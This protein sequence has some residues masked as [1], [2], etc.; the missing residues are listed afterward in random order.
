MSCI[1]KLRACRSDCEKAVVFC[2]REGE[3]LLENI[4]ERIDFADV[5]NV[6]RA[7]ALR[8]VWQYPPLS[9]FSKDKLN[10]DGTLK[11]GVSPIVA[12]FGFDEISSEIFKALLSAFAPVYN[13][14]GEIEGGQTTFLFFVNEEEKKKVYKEPYFDAVR[15]VKEMSDKSGYY[16]APLIPAETVFFG[17]ENEKTL[18]EILPEGAFVW[19]VV[20][21]KDGSR[22]EEVAKM[23]D[24]SGREAAVFYASD[25]DGGD[26]GV[27]S[28]DATEKAA[29]FYAFAERAAYLRSR[30]YDLLTAKNKEE[31]DNA[32]ALAE[33]E[34][35]YAESKVKRDS[36][37]Y[38]AL[39]LRQI[40]LSVG[41][42]CSNSGEDA[43]GDF[44][45]VYDSANPRVR[46][47]NGH[48]RYDNAMCA[49]KSV[50]LTLAKREHLRWNGYMLA[51]GISPASKAEHKNTDKNLLLKEGR[52]INLTTW[53]GLEEYRKDE[54][55][56]KGCS[57][58]ETDVQRYDF[59]LA[60]FAAFILGNNGLKIIRRKE[61]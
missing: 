4:G 2:D 23:L 33:R 25:I 29:G 51:C 14:D 46:D 56:R 52:H 12:F 58:E 20:A 6:P 39:A 57:E 18:K 37:L 27:Y 60:D 48:L 50:R 49:K 34:W 59:Q 41:F 44:D 21:D 28:F 1:E 13:V 45:R 30:I 3:R 38:A 9:F 32:L 24:V 8:L 26:H 40:L 17:R 42:D 15:R 31:F 47:E 11:N 22:A 61:S 43:T 7:A 35:K 5:I 53:E 10:N 36:N 54:A 16:E 55:A 19:A